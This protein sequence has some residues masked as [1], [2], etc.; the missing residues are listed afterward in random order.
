MAQVIEKYIYLP[1]EKSN[2]PLL[3]ID[4][5]SNVFK[6]TKISAKQTQKSLKRNERVQKRQRI[7]NRTTSKIF[8]AQ[9]HIFVYNNS[10]MTLLH[11][12]HFFYNLQ[13]L[14]SLLSFII[15]PLF[16]ILIANLDRKRF[17][18]KHSFMKGSW[19]TTKDVSICFI[20]YVIIKTHVI[21]TH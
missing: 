15:F 2:N 16:K 4:Y 14:I 17:N 9:H 20:N 10:R 1:G 3:H 8:T 18:N 13:K 21:K 12:F 11:Y 7:P 19:R 5:V 6:L